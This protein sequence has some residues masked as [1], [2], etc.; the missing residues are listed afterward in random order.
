MLFANG[1]SIL[2]LVNITVFAIK[3]FI[4]DGSRGAGYTFDQK[5]SKIKIYSVLPLHPKKGEWKVL[6][7]VH[8]FMILT[9]HWKSFSLSQD[10]EFRNT[11][12]FKEIQ[13]IF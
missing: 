8:R 1:K 9:I 7:T 3:V 10:I 13:T 12:H 5:L 2:R 4:L 6:L 11:F